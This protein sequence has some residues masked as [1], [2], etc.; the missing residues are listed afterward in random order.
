MRFL[1]GLLAVSSG[2]FLL[3]GEIH[4]LVCFLPLCYVQVTF[5]PRQHTTVSKKGMLHFTKAG[6]RYAME[7]RW[8]GS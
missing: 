8:R 1:F 3:P 7:T 6:F 4:V 5:L 2:Y